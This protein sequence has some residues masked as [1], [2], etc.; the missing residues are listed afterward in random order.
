[1]AATTVTQTFSTPGSGTYTVPSGNWYVVSCYI[2]GGG[3][4]GGGGSGGYGGGGGGQ[5][6]FELKNAC[7]KLLVGGDSITYT[8]GS[9]GAAGSAGVDGSDGSASSVSFSGTSFSTGY[10]VGG[11]AG[12]GSG[13][14]TGGASTDTGAP[15]NDA[16]FSD[17]GGDGGGGAAGG[18][19]AAGTVGVAPGGGGGGGADGFAGGA[20]ADGRV[21][22]VLLAADVLGT[23][24][25]P[26]IAVAGTNLTIQASTLV[27][28]DVGAGSSISITDPT[29]V[30]GTTHTVNDTA[31]QDAKTDIASVYTLLSGLPAISDFTGFALGADA[32]APNPDLRSLP[33][34]VYSWSGAAQ[35]INT[36]TL[37][38]AGIYIFKVAD[39]AGI[40]GTFRVENGSKIQLGSGATIDNVYFVT[41]SGIDVR[42]SESALGNF[43][44]PGNITANPVGTLF[45]Y[46]RLLSSAGSVTIGRLEGRLPT[47]F[48]YARDALI[49]TERGYVQ[50]DQIQLTD[51]VISK[52]MFGPNGK[53]EFMEPRSKKVTFVGKFTIANVTEK[54]APICFKAGSLGKNMPFKDL[55]IS[56]NHAIVH[57]GIKLGAECFLND[58]TIY[59]MTDVKLMEYYVI[60][61]EDHSVIDANGI[62]SESMLGDSSAFIS[63]H[64]TEK[65]EMHLPI[66][67]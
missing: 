9:G 8:V 43:I 27:E 52:G 22:F 7:S 5:S 63:V 34:G 18:S 45:M 50:I 47:A 10:G 44:T 30:H 41:Q 56:R 55:V 36:F 21:T 64:D 26:F 58:D 39:G 23:R 59:R 15:G 60:E 24:V 16:G 35:V 38:G 42:S 2:A 29:V 40:P 37:N 11:T 25:T 19:G 6:A 61:L 57:N 4:G 62:L 3:G 32:G 46:G 49:L 12:S 48:C 65:I 17:V 20:G 66:C 13:G 31:T 53:V 67:A 14:G 1:M 28:G 33:P 54:T 51:R